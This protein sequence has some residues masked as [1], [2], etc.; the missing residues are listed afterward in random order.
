M[1]SFRSL[2]LKS[3]FAGLTGLCMP[4]WLFFGYA[5]YY[6]KIESL[7]S[8]FTGA[9]SFSTHQ[10]W[11]IRNGQDHI[12]WNHHLD[13]T[14]QQRA[15]ISMF[16]YLDKV[17]T[18]IFLSFLITVEAWI[19]FTGYLTATAFRH[20][21]T[22]ANHCRSIL[23]GHLFTL[24]HN[25][26]TGIFFITTFVLL[27]VLTIYN[28]WMTILQFLDR[29]G[30]LGP[31]SRLFYSRKCSPV[32]LGGRTGSLCRSVGLRPGDQYSCRHRRQCCRR[33]DLLLDGTSGQYG[34]DRE[35]FSC[36]KREDGPCGAVC[37]RTGC[38]D[39]FPSSFIPILGSAYPLY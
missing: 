13:I 12:L 4:Y 31:F 39:G 23:T 11:D 35:I 20:P 16:S 30:I 14:G 18:R 25:R 6:D 22:D 27:I 28:L 5:F 17:R 38:L 9:Y 26:F 36:K 1:I 10:L 32:Q 15:F 19:L 7:L 29:L 33:H 34:M 3:F 37:T 24:T 21:V 2:S 8:P